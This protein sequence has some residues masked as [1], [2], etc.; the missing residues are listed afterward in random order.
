MLVPAIDYTFELEELFKENQYSDDVFLAFGQKDFI[1]PEW[2]VLNKYQYAVKDNDLVI[3]YLEYR[4][5][6]ETKSVSEIIMINFDKGKISFV[7]DVYN[8]FRELLKEFNRIEFCMV[9]GNPVEHHYDRL[10]KTYGG[11]KLILHDCI[12]DRHGK[13]IDQ[14][15]YEILCKENGDH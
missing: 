13:V 7:K 11:Q 5:D 10:I 2:G 15:I 4:V 6:Y 8:K 14:V 1:I 9:G 3:G 12:M